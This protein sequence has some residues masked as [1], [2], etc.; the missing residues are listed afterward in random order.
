MDEIVKPL[1]SEWLK[2]VEAASLVGVYPGTLYR[3][4][5][6]GQLPEG[7]CI[8]VD[9]TLYFQ[10]NALEPLRKVREGDRC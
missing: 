10:R 8:K 1:R 7:C 9:N 2:L 5:R 4:W 3:W 6:Y